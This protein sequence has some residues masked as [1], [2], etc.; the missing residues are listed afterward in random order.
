MRTSI[1]AGLGL[2][3]ATAVLLGSSTAT[4]TLA[5]TASNELEAVVQ[6]IIADYLAKHPDD[7]ER[8]VKDYLTRHPE[9][10][11]AALV[12]LLKKRSAGRPD[13]NVNKADLVRND[14]Q[15]LFQSAHQ[16]TLGNPQGEVTMVEFFDY[17]CGF[18]KRA[19]GDML[20]LMKTE[21][22]LRVVLK[23]LPV[24][25]A[26]SLEAARVAIAVRMQDV[27][28]S[29]YLAFHQKLLGSRGASKAAALAAAGEV[30]LDPARI[31]RDMES[32]EVTAT[33]EE[34]ARLAKTLGIT[35]TPSYVIGDNVIV[36]AVGLTALSDKIKR[37]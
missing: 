7:V 8:I 21:T 33:L 30:G 28:G 20:A 23:E 10:L 13:T 25:G 31:E 36:G 27:T 18:C 4:P 19:L 29:K 26:G 34:N 3:T 24:L 32:A 22:S 9:V 37:R 2:L 5:Q 6:S 12:E 16:V 15:A 35:G 17:N 11:Q 14:A 1:S